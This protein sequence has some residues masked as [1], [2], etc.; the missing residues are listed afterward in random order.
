MHTDAEI[1]LSLCSTEDR[2]LC[3]LRFARRCGQ[4]T[5]S[6]RSTKDRSLCLLSSA[7][8]T[9]LRLHNT[10]PSLH[11]GVSFRSFCMLFSKLNSN[12]G[13]SAARDECP[14]NYS[15]C[16]HVGTRM[17]NLVLCKNQTNSTC[18]VSLMF[19][20]PS[21]DPST[22]D[23]FSAT[24]LGCIY[25]CTKHPARMRVQQCTLYTY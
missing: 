16:T 8:I 18:D 19:S 17:R 7:V 25:A 13:R 1:A 5:L 10:L 15:K 20:R 14:A 24:S 22:A 4:T 11:R 9:T 12:S 2:S 6:P 23:S 21:P 3:L